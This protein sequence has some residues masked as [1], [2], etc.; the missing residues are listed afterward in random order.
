MT[1]RR[2]TSNGFVLAEALVALA[3]AAMTVALLTSATWGLN[4]ATERR[5]AAAQTSAVDWLAARRAMTGWAAGVTAQGIADSRNSLIG[6]ASTARMV[7]AQTNN[8]P[9]AG[10]YVG[11]LRIEARG[12]NR[13]VLIAAQHPGLRDARVTSSNARQTDVVTTSTPMRLLYLIPSGPAGQGVWRYETGSGAEG[14]PLAIGLEV[15]TRRMI[16]APIHPTRSASCL[17][18]LGL[19]GVDDDDCA[20]R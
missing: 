16:T 5:A 3:V 11:E 19:A 15:G 12:T 18:R 20:L 17:A 4:A 7:V 14:L 2:H 10:P 9:A 1:R 6:T 8:T 13:F